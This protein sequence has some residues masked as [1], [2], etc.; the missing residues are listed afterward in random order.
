[1]KQGCGVARERLRTTLSAYRSGCNF[2]LAIVFDTKQLAQAKLHKITYGSSRPQFPLRSQ[3]TQ[4][5]MKTV[6]ARYQSLKGNGH[7]WTKAQFK[8]PEYDFVWNRDYSLTKRLFSI[9]TLSGRVKVPFET[10]GIERYFDETWSFG[11][12]KLVNKYGKFFLYIP[13]T[14]EIPETSEHS[15]RQVAGVD[16]GINFVTVSYDSQGKSL[17]FNG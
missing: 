14:K 5:V 12:A 11:T 8:K 13:M 7:D 1:M 4:S 10:K 3:M 17:F 6:I 2:V 15:I 16:M 9:N